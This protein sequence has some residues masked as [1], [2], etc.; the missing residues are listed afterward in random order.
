M[1]KKGANEMTK[2]CGNCWF[3]CHADNKCYVDPRCAND[4]VFAPEMSTES[5]CPSWAFDC[6]EDWERETENALLTMESV[7]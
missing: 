5:S 7:A 2:N 4:G 6:L 3:Y 1:N